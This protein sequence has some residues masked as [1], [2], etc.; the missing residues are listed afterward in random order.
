MIPILIDSFRERRHAVHFG[1][2]GL[3]VA[4]SSMQA[5]AQPTIVFI[6]NY[7]VKLEVAEE[8]AHVSSQAKVRN[9]STF[10]IELQKYRID[11]SI[12][13]NGNGTYRAVVSLYE[14]ADG[15]WHKVNVDELSFKA[16]YAAPT[17]FLWS[18]GDIAMDMGIAVSIH[19]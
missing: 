6:A 15:G 12:N 16:M 13:N 4:L 18:A 8:R 5:L 14:R 11:V 1:V 10:P 7:D 17:Q 19:H 2:L 3:I 9:G